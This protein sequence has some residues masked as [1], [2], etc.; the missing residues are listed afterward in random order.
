[1][2]ALMPTL[3]R[4]WVGANPVEASLRLHGWS[5]ED[6]LWGVEMSLFVLP[7]ASV[8]PTFGVALTVR[9]SPD[10]RNLGNRQAV[11]IC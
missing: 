7:S 9:L 10:V 6:A 2:A 4:R 11:T 5:K 3:V 8:P 1:M